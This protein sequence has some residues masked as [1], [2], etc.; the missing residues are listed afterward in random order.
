VFWSAAAMVVLFYPMFAWLAASPTLQTLLIVQGVFGVLMAAYMGPLGAL[1]S[2]LF[3]PQMRTTGLSVSYAFGV[4]IFGGFAP[5]I[6]T[7]LIHMTGSSLAP[8]FY[9]ILSGIV[10]LIAVAS[11]RRVVPGYR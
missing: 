6:S 10:S 7:W 2:E 3:P 11:V 8:A 9:L 1:M 5:F 4:A